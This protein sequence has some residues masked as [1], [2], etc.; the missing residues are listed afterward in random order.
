M[1]RQLPIDKIILQAAIRLDQHVLNDVAGIDTLSELSIHAHVD[2][3]PQRLSM[4]SQKTVDGVAVPFGGPEQQFLRFFR[5]GPHGD[6]P[7]VRRVAD[8]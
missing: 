2:H 5:V 3:S 7:I 8:L 6:F 4:P 1:K